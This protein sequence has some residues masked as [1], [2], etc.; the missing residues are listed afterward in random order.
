MANSISELELNA[1]NEIISIANEFM[2]EE[3]QK[4]ATTNEDFKEEYKKSIPMVTYI[5]SPQKD[6][7]YK[8]SI[9]LRY[10]KPEES[11]TIW[12]HDGKFY[13]DSIPKDFTKRIKDKLYPEGQ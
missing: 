13:W 6:G 12:F 10:A 2:S 9:E 4:V 3:Y 5:N 8:S 1:L 11:I 7:H